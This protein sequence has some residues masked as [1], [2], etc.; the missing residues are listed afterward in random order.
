M[1]CVAIAEMKY[2]PELWVIPEVELVPSVI[3]SS[4]GPGST[5]VAGAS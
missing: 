3:S 4:V 5:L 1:G 2:V